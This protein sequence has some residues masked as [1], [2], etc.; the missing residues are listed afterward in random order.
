MSL[1]AVRPGYFTVEPVTEVPLSGNAVAWWQIGEVAY[2]VVSDVPGTE[3]ADEAELL[4][5]TLH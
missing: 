1:F 3:L 4:M 2:A 5:K